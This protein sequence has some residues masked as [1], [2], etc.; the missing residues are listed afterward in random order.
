MAAARRY[1][2]AG[3]LAYSARRIHF[4]RTVEEVQETVA[5]SSRI[6]ALG[7]GH[8]FN[9]I[10]DSVGDQ[11]SL[12]QLERRIEIDHERRVVK[13]DGGARYGD[14]CR[15]LDE[16]GFALPNLASL[17]HIAVAGACA[18]ATHGSGVKNKVLADSV[19][20]MDIVRSDGRLV[21]LSRERHPD[22]FPGAAVSL[23]ALGV[24]TSLTLDLVPA[25]DASQTV[26]ENLAFSQVESNFE[27]A[28]SAAY[29]VSLFTTWKEDIFEQV[30]VKRRAG[31]DSAESL[32]FVELGARLAAAAL[33]PIAELSAE[34]CTRQLGAPGPWYERLPH[35]RIEFTPSSGEELQSEYLIPREAVPAA[36]RAVASLR[37]RMVPLLLVS[38]LRAVARD[39]LWMSYCYDTDCVAIHFTWRQDWPALS[40]FL[41]ELERA[42]EPLGARPH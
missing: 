21:T 12:T 7:S 31:D 15:L 27:S 13:V 23:G 28:L 18:T 3:N 34:C 42:L 25:F 9:E 19:S 33:H 1:N 6:K 8:S 29:S 2:W 5:R 11:I 35:F 38:E 37:D 14:I 32:D 22:S 40:V 10:A 4:P 36:I 41:P 17:P 16:S 24:V 30:W 26:Y 20:E 39:D